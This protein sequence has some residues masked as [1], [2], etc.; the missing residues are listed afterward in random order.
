MIHQKTSSSGFTLLEV[1]IAVAIIVTGFFAVYSLHL[2]SIAASEVVRFYIKAPLLAQEKIAEIEG[3]LRN[4]SDSSGDFG[5]DFPGY[6]WKTNV[7]TAQSVLLGASAEKLKKIEI[8]I[9][10]D[11]GKDSYD[12]TVYRYVDNT[13]I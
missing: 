10:L 12:V 4:T 7:S 6:T 11:E 13:G 9:I 3:N 5:D 2:R 1:V 8:Q